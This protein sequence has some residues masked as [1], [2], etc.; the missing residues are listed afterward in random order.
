MQHV[1]NHILVACLAFLAACQTAPRPNAGTLVIAGGAVR[2]EGPIMPRFFAEATAAAERAAKANPTVEIV[3]TA[4]GDPAASLQRNQEFFLAMATHLTAQGLLLDSAVPDGAQNAGNAQ[5]LR[6]ASAVWF[7][8]GD[9]SRITEFFRPG[10]LESGDDELASTSTPCDQALR[11]MLAK[12]GVI[13][14]SS[15]GAAIMSQQMI[16]G[17][18]SESALTHGASPEGL[19]IRPGMDLFPYGLVD[20]HFLARGRL[21]RLL[22]AMQHTGERFG[23]GIEENSALIVRLGDE[24]MCEALGVQAVCIL[25]RGSSNA[26]HE[27]GV[28]TAELSML[29][30]GDRW[31]PINAQCKPAA[32]RIQWPAS[33]RTPPRDPAP[34]EAWEKGAIQSALL[35]LC[36][37]PGEPQVL[38]SPGHRLIL[39]SGPQTR[40]MVRAHRGIDLFADR[41]LLRIERKQ[42]ETQGAIRSLGD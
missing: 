20:Q 14:G 22:V 15:A 29:G 8:G 26:A 19:R 36:Q 41:V 25:D 16:A 17:G 42:T 27:D 13:G 7:A 12:G 5:R 11:H 37:Q 31:D 10:L 34:L 23:F 18:R 2:D 1:S 21:G 4:S 3:P 35:R 33:K 6:E 9:Q 39:S 38:D 28:W 30:S 32:D 24:P 40:Y